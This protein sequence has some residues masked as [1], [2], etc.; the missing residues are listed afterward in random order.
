MREL[1]EEEATRFSGGVKDASLLA[2]PY[3]LNSTTS[4]FSV[5]RLLPGHLHDLQNMDI[6]V[7]IDHSELGS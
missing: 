3:T 6:K 4:A 2:S 7:E 5:D 1:T